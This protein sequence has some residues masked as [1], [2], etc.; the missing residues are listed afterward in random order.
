MW[1]ETGCAGGSGK[2]PLRRSAILKAAFGKQLASSPTLARLTLKHHRPPSSQLAAIF[3]QRRNG[4]PG[5]TK[6][7]WKKE[8]NRAGLRFSAIWWPTCKEG[9]QTGNTW[10]SV[11]ALV[12]LVCAHQD[13][14]QQGTVVRML[15]CC[16][17]QAR[18]TQPSNADILP[19]HHLTPAYRNLHKPGEQVQA[20][21]PG[22]GVRHGGA[23]PVGG[24]PQ[25]QADARCSREWPR[26]GGS[27]PNKAQVYSSPS[28]RP[29]TCTAP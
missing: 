29:A 25:R 5:Q 22:P 1:W 26:A 21:R 11:Q 23:E 13:V 12:V 6:P 10:G 20:Q 7:T 24:S 4:Q 28:Q 3:R 14:G 8:S 19:P 15:A 17:A 16:G 18:H 27:Q 9:K 2:L